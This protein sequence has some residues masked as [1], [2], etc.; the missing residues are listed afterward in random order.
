MHL[1][2]DDLNW[3]IR[4]RIAQVGGGGG[5]GGVCCQRPSSDQ[6]FSNPANKNNNFNSFK[7]LNVNS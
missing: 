1:P 3:A 5:A 4:C 6:I 7:Q 2:L